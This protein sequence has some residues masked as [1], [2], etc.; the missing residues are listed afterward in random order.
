M[1]DDGDVDDRLAAAAHTIDALYELPYLAHAPMEPNNAVCRRRDDG[2]IEVWASTE[3]PEYTRMAAS[4]AA[5]VEADRIQVQ[6]DVRR[7]LVRAPQ[8]RDEGPDHRGRPGRQGPRLEAPHQGAV[9]ARRGVQERPLP[10]HRRCTGCEPAP[11]PRDTSPRS[12]TTSRP[13]RPH[14]TCPTSATS[15][16]PTT[17]TS[18][19]P[20]APIDNPYTLPGVQ[21]RVEQRRDRSPDD[22]VALGRQLPHRVRPGMRPRRA[23]ASRG[24]RPHRPAPRP[25]RCRPADPARPRRGRGRSRLGQASAGRTGPRCRL[26]RLPQPQR[27]DHRGLTRRPRTHPHRAHRVRPRLR[28]RHQPRPHPRPG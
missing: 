3:S 28:H 17:S 11:T 15:C 16:S 19:P 9:A 6:R 24:P 7:R 14:P 25:P 20:P 21:A 10:P 26:Q 4:S 8:Q 13:S 23:R 2:V 5:G 1:R 22:G 27:P 12:T 18:S